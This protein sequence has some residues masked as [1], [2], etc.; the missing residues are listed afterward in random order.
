MLACGFSRT[1][2][3]LIVFRALQGIAVAMDLPTAVSIITT[4]FASGKR[5]NLGLAFMGA[6]QPFGYLLG[7]VLGG[8]FIDTIG[9][10]AAYYVCAASNGIFFATSYWTIP[11][12]MNKSL[13]N[14]K[15]FKEEVDWVGA[16]IASVCLALLSYVLA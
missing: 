6:G 11:K 4:N 13:V 12:D 9:W 14:L 16:L 2:I 7:L 1:G 8:L 3:Q 5:R 15:H 10:R